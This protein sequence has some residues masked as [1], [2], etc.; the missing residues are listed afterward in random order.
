MRLSTRKKIVFAAIVML[1][2]LSVAEVFLRLVWQPPPPPDPFVGFS[3]SVPLL[4]QHQGPESTPTTVGINP[5]KLVWF[6]PQSFT[7]EKPKDTY[8]IVCLGGSTTYGRPFHDS[9]S[10][11]GWLRQLLPKSDPSR[12]WEV[13]NAGAISY[14]SYRVAVV[15]EQ[16]SPYDVDLF[17]VY[18]G[19]NE[20]LEWR[21][22]GESL[23]DA[24][25]LPLVSS[26]ALQTRLGQAS[27]LFAD[28][29]ISNEIPISGGGQ[30]TEL[31]GDV[32][33][34]LNHSVGPSSYTRDDNWHRGVNRHLAFNL[35]RMQQIAAQS[36]AK[37]AI[38]IPDSNLR[39]CEPFKSEFSTGLATGKADE[40]LDG[41]ATAKDMLAV[42]AVDDSI[43]IL[44]SVVEAQPRHALAHYL[45]GKGLFER[46]QY[47]EAERHFRT[48]IDE[49]ICPLRATSSVQST[50]REFA[51]SPGV[52]CVDFAEHLSKNSLQQFGHRCYGAERFL[53][54]VHPTIDSHG[55]LAKLLI[56]S[57]HD[58][59]IVATPVDPQT[60]AQTADAVHQSIDREQ[61]GIAFRNLAKLTHWAGKFDEA[62]RHA[63]DSLR[64]IDGDPESRYV[65]ADSLAKTGQTE[66]AMQEFAEL[67]EAGGFDRATFAYGDL[68]A[69]QGDLQR[70]KAY[71]L[72]AVLVSHG[73]RQRA[74]LE[75]LGWVHQQLGEED[76]A[77]ECFAEAEKLN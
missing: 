21:T 44:T 1:M 77:A 64:L 72:Q 29:W 61:Q 2:S 57:F 65:L 47:D 69:Q 6:N 12:N 19:Q 73:A 54:H 58:A 4:V 25:L 67:F 3:T 13:I 74:A 24:T 71:L 70:A 18:T 5:A 68:L 62:I 66:Q 76:L 49:D 28:R 56:D 33:E 34:I 42:G 55:E 46:Q 8:R 22:Y 52:I 26:I 11:A 32:D 41:I 9:T 10:F 48:A 17:V 45:L 23:R 43:A 31:S 60:F 53:D 75:S 27:Q 36:G 51:T 30:R 40:M 7:A 59:G 14:A 35:G 16:F 15:M 50:I 39:D 20:F 63:N 38:V 37:L